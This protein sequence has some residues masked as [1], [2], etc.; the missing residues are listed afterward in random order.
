[1]STQP[2][3]TLPYREVL[4]SLDLKQMGIELAQFSRDSRYLASIRSDLREQHPDCWVAVYHE[5]VV[6]AGPVLSDVFSKLAGRGIPKR[7]VALEYI[8]GE[9]L[10]LIL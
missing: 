8:T 4:E 9:P 2:K 7:N 5:E 10:M 6:A 1:M 3:E